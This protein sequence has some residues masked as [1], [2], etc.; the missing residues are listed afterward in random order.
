MVSSNPPTDE[1]GPRVMVVE[2][3]QVQESWA[4]QEVQL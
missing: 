2:P 1:V 3:L 4:L